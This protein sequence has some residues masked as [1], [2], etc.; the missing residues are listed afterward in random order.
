MNRHFIY[1]AMPESVLGAPIRKEEPK[2]PETPWKPTDTP[3]YVRRVNAQGI[4]EVSHVDNL[5]KPEPVITTLADCA[6]QAPEAATLGADDLTATTPDA[7][8]QWHV[9]THADGRPC[10]GR[11]IPG[12]GWTVHITED[13]A[14][15][16]ERFRR[17]SKLTCGV[18][19]DA[20]DE[21]LPAWAVAAIA[22]LAEP[23]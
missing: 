21:P 18:K 22:R 3:G 17:Y 20:K 11:L 1:S 23:V 13:E 14:A 4:T 15:D 16:M 5:P 6:A 7:A 9:V 2:S 8:H 10:I 12:E 19:W